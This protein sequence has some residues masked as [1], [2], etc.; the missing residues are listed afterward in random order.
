M[1]VAI[2]IY[3][4]IPL[5]FQY[6]I[7]FSSNLSQLLTLLD[8]LFLFFVIVNGFFLP[9]I[10]Y[11]LLI[12]RNSVYF[13]IDLVI[14]ILACNSENLAQLH[15]FSINIWPVTDNFISSFL[16]LT[17][18][19]CFSSLIAVILTS[20]TMLNRLVIHRRNSCVIINF[21]SGG[22]FFSISQFS[23]QAFWIYPFSDQGNAFL[24]LVIYFL[25]T[26]WMNIEFYQMLFLHLLR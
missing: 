26:S 16:I 17:L 22:E 21:R 20:S 18:L 9:F 6:F 15:S 19:I 4:F 12:R 14:S 7:V 1:S 23:V 11:F 3:C 24:L 10:F 5:S 2:H 13:C 8:V 25:F